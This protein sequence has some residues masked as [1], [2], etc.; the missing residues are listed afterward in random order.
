MAAIVLVALAVVMGADRRVSGV[1][2]GL[3]VFDGLTALD[4]VGPYEVLSRLPGASVR[5]IGCGG[6]GSWVDGGIARDDRR[7]IGV[8]ADVAMADVDPSS[9]EVLVVPGGFG[10]RPLMKD[11]AVLSWVRAVHA[12]STWTTSVCT[13]S[14][15]LGAAGLL[16]G[17]RATGHWLARDLLA[18]TGAVVVGDR[19]VREGKIVTSA[20]VS[21]GIDMALS[22]AGWIAGDEVAQSIQLAIE[23]DPQPPYDAGSPEKAPAAVVDRL[24]QRV[25]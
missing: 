5:W 6:D 13:G 9:V 7:S 20:G 3:L 19:V 2:I 21:S 8:A 11:E 23:Y 10:T 17:L 25:G 4:A 15:V 12:T 16:T 24:R 22:L 18:S 14:L 1:D